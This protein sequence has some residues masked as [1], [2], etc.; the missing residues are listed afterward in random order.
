MGYPWGHAT[1]TCT[2]YRSYAPGYNTQYTYGNV[3]HASGN[4]IYWISDSPSADAYFGAT[5]VVTLN[6]KT[7]AIEADTTYGTGLDDMALPDHLAEQMRIR[8]WTGAVVGRRS[9]N[10]AMASSP[11]GQHA[12]V[13]SNPYDMRVRSV[14]SSDPRSVYGTSDTT[15]VADSSGNTMQDSAGG[16]WYMVTTTPNQD[17]TVDITTHGSGGPSVPSRNIIDVTA[18]RGFNAAGKP[19]VWWTFHRKQ[20]CR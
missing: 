7:G 11:S 9:Y 12:L 20:V 14:D 2:D 6:H 16:G 10:P 17:G 8:D 1:C 4:V 15:I 3:L 19:G 18:T 5:T 13:G